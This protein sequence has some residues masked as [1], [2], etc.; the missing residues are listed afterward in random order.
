MT[1]A[2]VTLATVRSVQHLRGTAP[3]LGG[4]RSSE[5]EAP[6]K[7]ALRSVTAAG[8]LAVGLVTAGTAAVVQAA[9]PSPGSG[10][11]AAARAKAA[12]SA[13]QFIA[14]RPAILHTGSDEA[15][16][17][18]PVISSAGMQYIP[19]DRTYKGLPVVGGDLVVVADS[20]G[21]V[22][23]TSVA[24]QRPI[25]ALTV[26]PKLTSA[27]AVTVA[28]G[29]LSKVTE[30]ESTRLVVLALSTPRL[31]WESIVDGTGAEGVSRL[32]VD[33]DAST[34]AVLR[35]QEHVMHGSGTA[36][37]N[38]P[39]PVHIDT[40]G[41]G[42]SFSMRDPTVTNLSCQ[43]YST[44]S[45]LTGTD[46]LWGNGNA[47]NIETGCVDALFTAQTE[48]KMLSTWLGR[49]GMDGV[50][51][52]WPIRVGLNDLNAFYDGTQVAIGHNTANQWIGSL[53]VVGHEMG[54]GVDDHTPGGISGGNTQEFVADT[55]GAATEWFAN[56]PA[57]NDAPDFTVGEKINLV[58]SGPIRYMYNPSLA[59]DDNCYSSSIPS[60]E[61][62]AAAGPGN[63]WF[64]LLAEGTS[65]TNGQPTSPTCNGSSITGL[66][67]QN[68][69]KIMYNAM[70]MKTSG[71]SYLRYRVWTLQA[72]KNL[73]PG[74][75][76][77][78]DTVKAAWNAVSVPA[79][80]GEPT[81]TTG[82]PSPSP[83]VSPTG[84]PGNCSG[85]LLGNAG[86]ESGNTVWSA[87]AGVIGQ[88]GAS[89]PTHS[90]SWDAWLDGYGRTHTDSLAQSVSI[91]AGCHAT[92]SF[93]LHIDSS[94]STTVTA[95]DR[96]T[97]SVGG[98]TLATYSN[99]NK[100]GGY[101][102]R[103]FDVSSFA[104]QTVSVTFTGTED[105]SLQTSFVIDDTAL[106]LS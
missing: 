54:H 72:A 55:F 46:D 77:Q 7:F 20:A 58:G 3:T 42:T 73:F 50:G 44:R 78:F 63:H 105:V 22:R 59:G 67:I 13:D 47:T 35:T 25:G 86:F 99:L 31:A 65:P 1:A 82:T 71:S 64:Y 30:V 61:V 95:F 33:V 84:N 66:G 24:Q 80:S 4:P 21:Q 40:T 16:V 56:E 62:H 87:T 41:S 75:C 88:Y 68:A 101:A 29:Q 15:F 28:R 45:T 83:T 8:A 32:S 104:G 102:L 91:P 48:V 53:D 43:N 96:L 70:L 93:Y 38:G 85:Q 49:N 34:G 19:Y 76:T 89:E 26:A 18:Q 57:A 106:T 60:E 27:Q 90:G 52:A 12:A 69:M 9:P 51:G 79:Q 97:V 36:A 10:D 103:S 14:G 2:P 11:P 39:N 17:R 5:R 74:S 94:E 81:C 23:Y 6:L 37:W 92:L 98:S 100:A